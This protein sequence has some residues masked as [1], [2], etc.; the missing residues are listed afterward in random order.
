MTTLIIIAIIV[1]IAF[2]AVGIYNGLIK[3]RNTSEQAWSDVDVQ[4]KR[5]YD[6]IPNLIETVK[7]YA[8]HEKETFEKVVQARNQ[9]M[10]ASSPGE[11]AQAENFLQSTLKSLFALSE[12]YP[13]LKANQNFLDLQDELSNIEEQIQLARRYYNAVVRDLNT[14]IESVPSNIVANMFHFENR[15]YFELDSEEE[16][17][18][19]KVDFN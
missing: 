5:R 11:K 19:P 12:A 15:E 2:A 16:R 3:L 13:E 4:L 6:L 7:G 1:I 9:A 8:S 17:E 10:G 18:T 14:K